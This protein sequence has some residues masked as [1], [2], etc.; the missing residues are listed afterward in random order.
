M[1]G[2]LLRLSLTVQVICTQAVK[3]ACS[4]VSAQIQVVLVKV[5]GESS[6]PIAV[7]GSLSK[8]DY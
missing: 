1:S 6:I 2:I 7:M 8:V 3:L 4:E 5:Q